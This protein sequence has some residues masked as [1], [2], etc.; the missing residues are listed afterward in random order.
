[1]FL[2]HGEFVD[3]RMR[4]FSERTD[5][6]VLLTLID[7]RIGCLPSESVDIRHAAGRVLAESVRSAVNVPAFHRSA[8]DGYAVAADNTPGEFTIVGQVFPGRPFDGVVETGEAI[9]IMTGAP[10]PAGVDCVVPVEQVELSHGRVTVSK[11]S[12]PGKHVGLCGEDITAG[13]RVLS[14]GRM[15]R[16]QD[17]G[18]LASIGVAQVRVVRRPRVAVF[19]TGNELVE[20]G[21]PPDEFRIVDS[22]S[23]MLATLLERD[24]AEMG[25]MVMLEDRQ[26]VIRAALTACEADL[27]VVTGGSSVGLEDFAPSIVAELGELLVH[28]VNM[29]PAA[30][31]GFGFI[32]DRPVFLLPGNPVSCLCAYDVVVGRAVRRLGGRPIDSPYRIET[33]PLAEKLPSIE[34]RVYYVRVLVD[35]GKVHPLKSAAGSGASILSGACRADGYVLVPKETSA[36]NQ[37]ECVTVYFYDR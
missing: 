3:V 10:L 35:S 4:G 34:G 12:A 2:H 29:R 37:G 20:C 23:I 24:G 11:S 26:E 32:K 31:L 9:A 27:V 14:A 5:V 19:V 6:D 1:M 25:Q 8:M 17:L 21:K 30:P 18:M 13:E 22:N 33:L 36:L 16:P 7:R 15:L 28:G